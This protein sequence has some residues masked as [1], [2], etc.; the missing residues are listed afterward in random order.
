MWITLLLHRQQEHE[1]HL[2]TVLYRPSGYH[3]FTQSGIVPPSLWVALEFYIEYPVVR[4]ATKLRESGFWT[5]KPYGYSDIMYE[6]REFWRCQTDCATRKPTFM[7]NFRVGF[8]TRAEGRTADVLQGVSR[9][10][11]SVAESYNLPEAKVL[12]VLNTCQ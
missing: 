6:V 11:N 7:T 9:I 4:N 2:R 1:Q 12:A 8:A 10:H 3:T 5:T